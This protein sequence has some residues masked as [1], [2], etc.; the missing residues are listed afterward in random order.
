[1]NKDSNP[2]CQLGIGGRGTLGGQLDYQIGISDFK[3]RLYYDFQ[4]LV[5]IV[6]IQILAFFK[7]IN[8][9]L[10]PDMPSKNNIITRVVKGVNIYPFPN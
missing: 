10:K 4:S 5:N 2:L 7:S 3:N 1:M 9:G 8:L 6:P